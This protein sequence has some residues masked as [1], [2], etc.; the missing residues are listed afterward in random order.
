MFS[1]GCIVHVCHC[2]QVTQPKWCLS[3]LQQNTSLTLLLVKP[4]GTK[5]DSA[6]C[7]IFF[8]FFDLFSHLCP[9][10]NLR[11]NKKGTIPLYPPLLAHLLVQLKEALPEHWGLSW[12]LAVPVLLL[13]HQALLSCTRRDPTCPAAALTVSVQEF[14]NFSGAGEIFWSLSS[15]PV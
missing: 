5:S 10:A 12:L 6:H 9:L 11:S 15:W 4:K 7:M 14:F 2:T 13:S 1:H 8:F 3:Q